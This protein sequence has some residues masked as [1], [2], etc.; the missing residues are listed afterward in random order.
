M[1]Q[2]SKDKVQEAEKSYLDLNHVWRQENEDDN[3]DVP[4]KR[5]HEIAKDEIQEGEKS[6]LDLNH[7]WR[8]ENEDD[9]EDVPWQ[10]FHEIAKDKVQEGEKSYLDLNREW[11]QENEDD[12][13]DAPQQRFH[14][15][16]SS[17]SAVL[18]DS[19]SG[20][21]VRDKGKKIVG[22]TSL[23]TTPTILEEK[24]EEEMPQVVYE[25]LDDIP[26]LAKTYVKTP[27][28]MKRKR[29]D[30]DPSER[31]SITKRI[32]FGYPLVV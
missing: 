13:E 6:Y 18:C 15:D 7:V 26:P 29:G 23:L 5:F 31:S 27:P 9:N 21:A 14:E 22:F 19:G 10:R 20:S 32:N 28:K 12:N 2:I 8:Q 17:V 1:F 16:T 3:E 30:E 25:N 11:R 24:E 4:Q